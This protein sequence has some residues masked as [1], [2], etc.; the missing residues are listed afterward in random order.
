MTITSVKSGNWSNPATWGESSGSLP[1]GYGDT[2][3]I[4]HQITLD[5]NFSVGGIDPASVGTLIA[6]LSPQGLPLSYTLQL[7]HPGI[8]GLVRGI[9]TSA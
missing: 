5:G 9:N 3:V 6:A 8:V 7:G 2:A 1:P 4:N